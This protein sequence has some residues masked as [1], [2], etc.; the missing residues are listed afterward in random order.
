MYDEGETHRGRAAIRKW[1]A[2]TTEKY[3]PQVEALRTEEKD[4]RLVVTARV[5]GDFPGSPVELEFAFRLEGGK[6]RELVVL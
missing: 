4:G 1:I 3:H 2:G 6:I 5:E